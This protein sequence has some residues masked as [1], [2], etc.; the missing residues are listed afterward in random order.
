[1]Q[2]MLPI[3]GAIAMAAC[4]IGFNSMR[5][6]RIWEAVNA[7]A[8]SPEAAEIAAL[9]VKNAHSDYLISSPITAGTQTASSKKAES[10]AAS[11]DEQAGAGST[12]SNTA[13]QEKTTTALTE[14]S[15]EVA[16]TPIALPGKEPPPAPTTSSIMADVTEAVGSNE[17]G[18]P[19]DRPMTAVPLD[20]SS[21]AAKLRELV[22]GE[23][24]RLPP[25]DPNVPPPYAQYDGGG[26]GIPF[27]PS[28]GK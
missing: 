18:E 9:P 19:G 10:Q 21:E 1:M 16:A 11:P 26:E 7:T 14:K 27:Y 28:T 4:C 3:F 24:R 23:I 5:Y 20:A 25:V 6:P 13:M 17:N 12:L 22:G 15:K 2:K 8:G